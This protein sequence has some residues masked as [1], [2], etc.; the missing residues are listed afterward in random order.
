MGP[1]LSVTVGILYA[2]AFRPVLHGYADSAIVGAALGIPA[3]IAA[4]EARLRRPTGTAA[5][6]VWLF[7]LGM[8]VRLPLLLG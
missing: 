8:G 2:A 3:W 7:V 1:L 5:P 6:A 4:R